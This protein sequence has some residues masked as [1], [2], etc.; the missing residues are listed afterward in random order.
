MQDH[1]DALATEL[2]KSLK[3]ELQENGALCQAQFADLC[4]QLTDKKAEITARTEMYQ[5][6]CLSSQISA[7]LCLDSYVNKEIYTSRCACLCCVI[8][9]I[10][11]VPIKSTLSF[12]F[13]L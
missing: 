4:N 5:K 6:V 11:A 7:L 3:K 13:L 9:D 2:S 8:A 10:P 12:V 1:I